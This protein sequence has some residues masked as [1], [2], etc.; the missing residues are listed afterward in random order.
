MDMGG[1]TKDLT[2]DVFNGFLHIVTL[3]LAFQE[4]NPIHQ[5]LCGDNGQVYR[6]KQE[7]WTIGIKGE[8]DSKE[9][10]LSAEL[11]DDVFTWGQE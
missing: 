11:A 3:V 8:R 7:S 9:S 4:K 6:T 1:N 5:W 2:K 10:V